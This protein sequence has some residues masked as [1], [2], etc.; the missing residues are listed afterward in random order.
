[1]I[2]TGIQDQLQ[3]FVHHPRNQPWETTTHNQRSPTIFSEHEKVLPFV[4]FVGSEGPLKVKIINN[5]KRRK[6][7]W[8]RNSRKFVILPWWMS[9]LMLSDHSKTLSHCI[10]P[11]H[12]IYNSCMFPV[13]WSLIYY[14]S[15]F[16][17][18]TFD[19]GIGNDFKDF[20]LRN[21]WIQY[22]IECEVVR[23]L[24]SWYLPKID[25]MIKQNNS[26]IQLNCSALLMSWRIG[27][28]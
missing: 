7:R 1:M 19:D 3:D 5:I 21:H 2:C 27:Q 23:L 25:H 15:R 8:R 9:C 24:R 12:L 28:T 18:V 14:F 26:N 22:L 17:A 6:R 10:L 13:N 4:S 16:G 11:S 20:F